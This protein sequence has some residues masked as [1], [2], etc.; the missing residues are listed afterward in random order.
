MKS[1]IASPD[2]FI[3][4]WWVDLLSI[5]VKMNKSPVLVMS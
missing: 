2:H 4:V 1:D 5:H 3:F